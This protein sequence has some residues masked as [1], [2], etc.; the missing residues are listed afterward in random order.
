MDQTFVTERAQAYMGKR[1]AN[2]NATLIAAAVRHVEVDVEQANAAEYA[3]QKDTAVPELWNRLETELQ[4]DVQAFNTAC[5]SEEMAVMFVA[6]GTVRVFLTKW[7]AVDAVALAM[8]L[9]TGVLTYT[10]PGG[11]DR[12]WPTAYSATDKAI[13]FRTGKGFEDAVSLA[14]AIIDLVTQAHI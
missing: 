10:Q 9:R 2:I 6:D 14:E 3:Q 5:G 8:N 13:L 7:P 11:F 12:T 4:A 1:S